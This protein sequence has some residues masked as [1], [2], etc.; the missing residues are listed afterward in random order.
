M[1]K[2]HKTKKELEPE[3]IQK[4]S[5]FGRKLFRLIGIESARSKRLRKNKEN[6]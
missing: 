3:R 2:K 6:N 5:D 1:T 4:G